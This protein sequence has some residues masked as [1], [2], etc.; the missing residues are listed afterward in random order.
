MNLP[1]GRVRAINVSMA[2]FMTAAYQVSPS[3]I[4]GAPAWFDSEEFDMEATSEDN[5][6]YDEN[7]MRLQSLLADRFKLVLSRQAKEVPV[8]ALTLDKGGSKL[9]EKQR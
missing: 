8:Y 7:R 5:S 1:G 2:G 3:R 9:H 4:L 6:T